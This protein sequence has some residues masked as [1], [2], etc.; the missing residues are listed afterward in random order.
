[1]P[2]QSLWMLAFPQ[3]ISTSVTH[4]CHSPHLHCYP[5]THHLTTTFLHYHLLILMK[6]CCPFVIPATSHSLQNPIHQMRSPKVTITSTDFQ[7][8]MQSSNT[9]QTWSLN[10][11]R[12]LDTFDGEWITHVF[13]I[14]TDP[15]TYYDSPQSSFQY[16]LRN[17]HGGH[18]GVKCHLILDDTSPPVLSD[19]SG[20]PVL[21]DHLH[22]SCKYLFIVT[23]ITHWQQSIGRGLKICSMCDQSELILMHAHMN[24]GHVHSI[25]S[26]DSLSAAKTA[27]CE[28][29]MKTLAFFCALQDCGCSF[30]AAAEYIG[31]IQHDEEHGKSY[32]DL[33]NDVEA[34]ST[35]Q[36]WCNSHHPK[37]AANTCMGKP[38][39]QHDHFNSPF[40]Q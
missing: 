40:I 34:I 5:A 15:N 18:K 24:H 8:L 37:P 30:S 9:L 1:M 7:Q 29:F 25:I 27:A 35:S 36:H 21:C 20:A 3:L 28:V 32:S 31:I 22:T 19:H 39:L 2:M 33:E 16:L 4:H 23:S 6:F 12:V 14:G 26:P 13:T 11:L 17:I 10:I 38:I